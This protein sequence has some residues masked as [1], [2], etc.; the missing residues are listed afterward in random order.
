[1]HLLREVEKLRPFSPLGMYDDFPTSFL[2]LPMQRSLFVL[3]N[4][5]VLAFVISEADLTLVRL[6]A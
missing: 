5:S 4:L 2:F 3:T 6:R 1:V